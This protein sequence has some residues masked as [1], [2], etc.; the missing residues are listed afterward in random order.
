MSLPIL[1]FLKSVL[2][3]LSS[4][5]LQMNVKSQ[6]DFFLQ[7]D[8]ENVMLSEVNKKEKYCMISLICGI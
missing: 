1:F 6:L 4:S 5:K 3:I 2:A 8:L 7:V